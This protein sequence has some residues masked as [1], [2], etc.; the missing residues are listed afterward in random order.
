MI[1]VDD[2]HDL[3]P[4]IAT[5]ILGRIRVTGIGILGTIRRDGSPR[6]SPIEV[7]IQDRS[8]FMGMMADSLKLRDVRRDPRC[9]LLTPV[10][11]RNDLGGEGKLFGR[12]QEMHGPDAERVLRQAALDAGLD[13][14]L[15]V[16]SPAFELLVDAAAWQCVEGE[17]FVTLSWKIGQPVRLRHRVGALGLPGDVPIS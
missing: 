9:V 1:S 5:A 3:A 2:L 6:I 16:G 10:A 17:T 14:E 15:V 11:D 4:A 8:L 7:S 12:L 13:P